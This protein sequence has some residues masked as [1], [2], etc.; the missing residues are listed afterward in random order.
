MVNL[1]LNLPSIALISLK[2]M[3][4]DRIIAVK[5]QIIVTL[6]TKSRVILILVGILVLFVYLALLHDG[7]NTYHQEASRVTSMISNNP[8]FFTTIFNDIFP[9]AL[10]CSRDTDTCVAQTRQR[11]DVISISPAGYA[12]HNQPSNMHPMYFITV[13]PDG[14]IAKLFFSGDI[15]IEEVNTREERFVCSVGSNYSLLF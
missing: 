15:R 12:V 4:H 9:S 7:R 8:G 1:I 13:Q 11:L 10:Q 2:M 3:R 14:K 5:K 6:L